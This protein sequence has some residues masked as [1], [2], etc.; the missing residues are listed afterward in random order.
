[1]RIAMLSDAVLP[2]PVHGGHGLGLM[3]SH[4]TEALLARGHDITL[5]GAPGSASSGPAVTPDDAH[6]YA[7]EQALARESM[8]QH[9]IWPYDVFY[10]N[11]HLHYLSHMFPDLPIVNH[12]HD[13]YQPPS[14]CMVL[15]SYGQQAIMPPEFERAIVIHNALDPQKI[16]PGY[17]PKDYVLWMGALQEFKQPILAIEACARLGIKLVIAG[18]PVGGGLP[19]DKHSNVEYI[20]VAHGTYRDKLMREARVFL[21]L[22]ALE[23]F[24]LTTLEAGLSG[25]PTVAWPGGGSLDII[26]YGLNGVFV[27][28]V[29]GDVTQAVCDAIER[30]W[31]MPRP[32][33][34]SYT[35]QISDPGRQIDEVE[36]AL[37]SCARGAWW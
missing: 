23:S 18:A 33:V 1:M 3:V 2:T 24:G 16:R 4:V 20:G 22:G 31:Y 35:E 13:I 25:T 21:Q 7:G 37:V 36:Q 9:R 8:R 34:R 27:P 17:D 6:G 26:R 29:S 10:D 11:G 32:V 15:C 30:A 12:Y 5:F 19:F 28:A 14:R